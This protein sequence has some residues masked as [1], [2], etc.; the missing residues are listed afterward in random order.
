MDEYV[1]MSGTLR[2]SA[3]LGF[4]W[5]AGLFYFPALT[6][7]RSPD[8]GG[9]DHGVGE[10]L[11]HQIAVTEFLG[12]VRGSAWSTAGGSPQ[13][14]APAPA[15]GSSILLASLPPRISLYP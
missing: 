13:L 7:L 3:V 14:L 5:P 8:R 4:P 9:E 15:L 10:G 1:C 11:F 6:P 2:V 12:R